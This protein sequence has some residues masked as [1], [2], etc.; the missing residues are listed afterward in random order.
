MAPY[1]APSHDGSYSTPLP[2]RNNCNNQDDVIF[3]LTERLRERDSQVRQLS[4]E[5]EE[6]EH[7]L[8]QLQ[9]LN[10]PTNN[11]LNH[12]YEELLSHLKER[13]EAFQSES[14]KQNDRL[15]ELEK[16]NGKL[17]DK[18]QTSRKLLDEQEKQMTIMEDERDEDMESIQR[19]LHVTMGEN[20]EKDRQIAMLEEMVDS[21]ELEADEAKEKQVEDKDLL[22]RVGER[23]EGYR[24][25]QQDLM[26]ENEALHKRVETQH[27]LLK[28]KDEELVQ[29][30]RFRDQ[31]ED[32]LTEDL[33]QM[34]GRLNEFVKYGRMALEEREEEIHLLYQQC[35]A[36]EEII[37]EADY[38]T[39]EQRADLKEKKREIEQLSLAIEK[40]QN[41]GF[42]SQLDN[43]CR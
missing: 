21:L 20:R 30:E 22:A 1:H 36:Y 28:E 3:S 16:E 35:E 12:A 33:E 38:V 34:R 24:Q 4:I 39:Y 17:K 31:R 11:E 41:Q 7:Q 19:R 26:K 27:E 32:E 8:L 42:L 13:E 40:V 14:K 10:N 6:L 43:L 23:L 29:M 5:N 9:S 18:L 15:R 2:L 25:N 37:D